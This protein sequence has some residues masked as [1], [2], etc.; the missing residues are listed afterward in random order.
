MWST[1]RVQQLTCSACG[2]GQRTRIA[3]FGNT[4]VMPECESCGHTD[5]WVS[6]PTLREPSVP[7]PA[8]SYMPTNEEFLA[9]MAE[10]FLMPGWRFEVGPDA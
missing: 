4:E 8:L 7:L 1:F 3:L 2:Y 6:W 9:K 10:M 5:S